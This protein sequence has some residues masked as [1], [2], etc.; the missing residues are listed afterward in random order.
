MRTSWITGGSKSLMRLK[1]GRPRGTEAN[2]NWQVGMKQISPR[3][4]L[5]F[6]PQIHGNI[7]L[8]CFSY[9]CVLIGYGSLRK[10]IH[11]ERVVSRWLPKVGS[12]QACFSCSCCPAW[13]CTFPRTS[14]L[15]DW[16]RGVSCGGI[17]ACHQDNSTRQ[18]LLQSRPP[19]CPGIT[20][21]F[22]TPAASFPCLPPIW[23]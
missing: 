11:V 17:E 4:L 9:R 13:D 23:S 12:L 7:S 15:G 14:I 21:T 1:R 16:A 19:G 8:C 10:H 3:C 5:D 2:R 20:R 18:H 6:G 22:C